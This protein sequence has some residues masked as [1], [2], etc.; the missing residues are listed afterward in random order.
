[1]AMTQTEAVLMRKRRALD[2]L[3]LALIV[4]LAAAGFVMMGSASMD[5]AGEQYGNPFYHIIRH[6]IYLLLGAGALVFA[7]AGTV[8]APGMDEA[9]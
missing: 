4:G 8:V 1:M 7:M 6:G 3:L 5:Y 9:E 2:H